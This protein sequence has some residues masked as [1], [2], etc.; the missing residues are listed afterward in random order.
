V[1]GYFLSV[2]IYIGARYPRRS[3]RR[4]GDRR[5]VRDTSTLTQA[6][7]TSNLQADRVFATHTAGED[8]DNAN[9]PLIVGQASISTLTSVPCRVASQVRILR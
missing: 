4:L 5:R 3:Q 1:A 6:P 8:R 7:E 2:L 9:S